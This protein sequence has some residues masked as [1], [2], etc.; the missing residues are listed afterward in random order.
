MSTN[1]DPIVTVSAVDLMPD[2]EYRY[3]LIEGEVLLSSAPA[4]THQAV[5]DDLVVLLRNWIAFS[6]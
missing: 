1:V 3:E 6:G 4:L 2:D 5:L